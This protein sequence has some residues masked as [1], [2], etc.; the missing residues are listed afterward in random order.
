MIP[1]VIGLAIFFGVHLL[2]TSPD[3]RQGLISRYG[4][5]AYKIGFALASLV[6][7]V[8]I[9][10]G[11]HKL[12]LHPEKAGPL[13]DPPNWT[14]HVAHLLM[15]PALIVL[16]AAYIPSHIRRI[17]KHPML[18][19]I[20]LWALAHLIAAG[21]SVAALI[22]FGSFLA[23]AVFDRISVKRRGDEG[24]T[25]SPPS[26]LGDFAAIAIGSALYAALLLGGHLW[27]IGVP[28]SNISV[29]Q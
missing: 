27:L 16:V 12:Q 1:M 10:I 25:T 8:L 5:N 9:V 14:R 2:P 13:W 23:F 11:F 3:L 21:S 19:A 29:F 28:V 22:L 6:G 15:L 4:A 20:K 7:F 18:V 24:W 17:L 26:I